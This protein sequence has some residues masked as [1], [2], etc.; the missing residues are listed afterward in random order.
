LTEA[1]ALALGERTIAAGTSPALFAYASARKGGLFGGDAA[2]E[3]D[4]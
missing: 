4:V 2:K 3:L 1:R